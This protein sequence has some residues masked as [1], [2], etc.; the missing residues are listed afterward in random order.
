MFMWTMIMLLWLIPLTLGAV[1]VVRM[2][3]GIRPIKRE[4]WRLLFG[5]SKQPTLSF[6]MGLKFAALAIGLFILGVTEAVILPNLGTFWFLLAPL[7]TAG[8]TI[9]LLAMWL[10]SGSTSFRMQP[11]HT[12]G[13]SRVADIFFR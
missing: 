6:W 4:E 2:A 13:G 1:V 9:L 8:A 3:I 7:L 5:K 11:K 12:A 10:R